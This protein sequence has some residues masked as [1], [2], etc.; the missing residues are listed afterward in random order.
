MCTCE[1]ERLTPF[2]SPPSYCVLHTRLQR[3]S[4]Q[5]LQR[6]Q[7]QCAP[8]HGQRERPLARRPELLL[9]LGRRLGVGFGAGAQAGVAVERQRAGAAEKLRGVPQAA[10]VAEAEQRAACAGAGRQVGF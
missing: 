4:G 5:R 9:Q 8:P 2:P 10:V 1:R 7:R 6:P 3:L